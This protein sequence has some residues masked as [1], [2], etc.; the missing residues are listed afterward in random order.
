MGSLFSSIGDAIGYASSGAERGRQSRAA[1]DTRDEWGGL[2]TDVQGRPVDDPYANLGKNPNAAAA[3][4]AV[5][6][7]QGMSHGTGLTPQDAS[8]LQAAQLS[9]AQQQG[10]ALQ[11]IQNQAQAAGTLNSGRALA[12]QLQAT[13]AAGNANAQAGAQAAAN[14]GQERQNAM[15][16]VGQ[17]GQQLQGQQ[18]QNQ[19]FNSAQN[20]QAQEAQRQNEANRV[21]GIG[22]ANQTLIDLNKKQAEGIQGVGKNIGNAVGQ[23]ASAAATGGMSGLLGMFGG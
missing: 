19:Q 16:Q 11:G 23:A 8:A 5:Q 4:Q 13:Q 6:D 2:R 1:G 3:N 15:G 7:L 10:S 18:L 17:L 14:S 21:Q 20:V 9:N 12:G 22:G